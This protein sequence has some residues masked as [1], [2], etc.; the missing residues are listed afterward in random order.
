MALVKKGDTLF[1][2]DP[3][4]MRAQ[5]AQ[6]QASVAQA[7]AALTLA[8]SELKRYNSIA[9]TNAVS[10]S[11]VE[12]RQ[13]AVKVAEALRDA[14]TA[15]VAT[16]QLNVDFTEIKSPID[17]RAGS[18]MVDVGNVVKA[19]ETALL[20]IQRLDQVYVDFT[21][22]E[23]QLTAVRENMASG[24]LKVL[25]RVPDEQGEGRAGTLTFIDNAVQ[26]ATGTVRLRATI[27]NKDQHFWPG[28]FVQVRL[29]LKTL[30]DA[31]LVPV[32]A[33]QLSQMGQYVIVVH[34][35][36]TAEMRPVVLGQ[37]QGDLVVLASGVK[38]GEKVVIEGQM[39]V[40]PGAKVRLPEKPSTTAPA[41]S[42]AVPAT[43]PPPATNPTTQPDK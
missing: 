29:V 12:T 21:I 16:A 33:P 14:A 28:Q 11:D 27:D 5:L 40:R 32:A 25:A 4:P 30:K 3:R 31:V 9:G 18:R 19:N 36:M 15:S 24:D 37:A 17:G 43:N 39:M 34:D 38:S 35:D 1:V 8:N 23:A 6:S 22:N 13:N 7:E 42:T 2:L 20:S 41:P 26:D 10:A